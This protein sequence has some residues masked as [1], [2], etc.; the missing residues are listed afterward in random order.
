MNCKLLKSKL[1]RAHSFIDATEHVV[2][3]VIDIAQ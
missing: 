3:F 1:V 2:A